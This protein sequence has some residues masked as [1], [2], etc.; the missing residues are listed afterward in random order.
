MVLGYLSSKERGKKL[1]R[2]SKDLKKSAS[3][4][5][6]PAAAG[7]SAISRPSSGESR[8]DNSLVYLAV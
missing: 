5:R 4:A 7:A 6:P 8:A 3:G 2:R 1:W